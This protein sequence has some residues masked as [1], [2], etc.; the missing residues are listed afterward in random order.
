MNCSEKTSSQ[1]AQKVKKGILTT[2]IASIVVVSMSTS[3]FGAVNVYFK[4]RTQLNATQTSVYTN[5]YGANHGQARG[6]NNSGSAGSFLIQLQ[7]TT[8][9]GWKVLA[10]ETVI[11]GRTVS[12]SIWGRHDTDYL[13]RGRAY[14][15]NPPI[16]GYPGRVGSVSIYT[17]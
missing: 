13:F 12:T 14:V 1:L 8:G 3:I 15:P 2:V 5:Q 7:N 11:A 16:F 4:Q 9:D 6:T 10:E 17:D